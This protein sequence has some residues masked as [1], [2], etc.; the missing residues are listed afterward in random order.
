ML[1]SWH[2]FDHLTKRTLIIYPAPVNYFPKYFRA[3]FREIL[4]S[5]SW[6]RSVFPRKLLRI[7]SQFSYACAAFDWV[8]FWE[9]T[10]HGPLPWTRSM[11]WVHQIMDRV[12]GPRI[13]ITPYKKA[14]LLDC[15]L[16]LSCENCFARPFG[17]RFRVISV[18]FR[19]RAC[20]QHVQNGSFFKTAWLARETN[21]CFLLGNEYRDLKMFYLL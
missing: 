10:K 7:Q 13:L 21:H 2:Y 9:G 6:E 20:T 17:A 11:D 8:I 4:T 5:G 18:R 3:K 19:A 16:T 15:W 12:H 14:G 1:E